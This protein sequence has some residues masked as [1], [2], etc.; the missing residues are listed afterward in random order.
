MLIDE[1]GSG[2]STSLYVPQYETGWDGFQEDFGFVHVT[3][4]LSLLDKPHNGVLPELLDD[5]PCP[6]LRVEGYQGNW[7]GVSLPLVQLVPAVP[8]CKVVE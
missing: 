2:D 6:H 5:H 3:F 1:I 4:K 7:P 8:A